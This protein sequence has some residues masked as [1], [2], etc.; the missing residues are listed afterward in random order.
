[1]RKDMGEGESGGGKEKEE[2]EEQRSEE[3]RGQSP[4][5]C[6]GTDCSL[7]PLGFLGELGA[8]WWMCHRNTDAFPATCK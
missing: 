3:E 5:L 7:S 4:D 1:M 2:V 8:P 6:R